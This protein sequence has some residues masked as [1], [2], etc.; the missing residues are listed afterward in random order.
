MV[1]GDAGLRD[2]IGTAAL[3]RQEPSRDVQQDSERAAESLSVH[4]SRDI[5]S[6]CVEGSFT[7]THMTCAVVC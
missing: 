5:L 1:A 7:D 6:P 3:L 2:D 4:V